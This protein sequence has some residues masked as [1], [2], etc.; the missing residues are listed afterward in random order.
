MSII[1]IDLGDEVM[2]TKPHNDI[3]LRPRASTRFSRTHSY[4]STPTEISPLASSS[5]RSPFSGRESPISGKAR[6]RH[7]ELDRKTPFGEGFGEGFTPPEF[8]M[9]RGRLLSRDSTAEPQEVMLLNIEYMLAEYRNADWDYQQIL[10]DMLEPRPFERVTT[11]LSEY[12][13]PDSGCHTIQRLLNH[14]IANFNRIITLPRGSIR[15][16]IDLTGFGGHRDTF[17]ILGI[18]RK[19]RRDIELPASV[20]R[21]LLTIIDF[22]TYLAIR[23]TCRSWSR[24]ISEVRPPW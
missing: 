22:D 14:G 24:A 4:R 13:T 10:E 12:V 17:A 23:L 15:D 2:T 18:R 1:E 7:T 11:N 6:N 8:E 9:L 20:F 19:Q 5:P 21:C 16:S 3:P